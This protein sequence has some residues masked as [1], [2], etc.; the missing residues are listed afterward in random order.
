MT[1][2]VTCKR[3]EVEADGWCHHYGPYFDRLMCDECVF[4]ERVGNASGAPRIR[5]PMTREELDTAIEIATIAGRNLT[6]IQGFKCRDPGG[7]C[8]DIDDLRLSSR[9]AKP[10]IDALLMVLRDKRDGL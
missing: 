4:K 8:R 3:N 5:G 7:A 1:I 9:E 10:V 6:V 2:C